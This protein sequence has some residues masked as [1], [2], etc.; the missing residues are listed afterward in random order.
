MKTHIL[1]T[2][3]YLEDSLAP[4][5]DEDTQK[6]A[7]SSL[8]VFINFMG[9]EYLSS[10]KFKILATLRISLNFNRADFRKLSCKAWY[11]FIKKYV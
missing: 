9:A 2:L 10:F 3:V 7:L 1:A 11:T 4:K 8:S 6:S 5:H